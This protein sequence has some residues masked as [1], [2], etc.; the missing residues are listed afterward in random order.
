VGL[1]EDLKPGPVALDTQVFIY[2]IEEDKQFLPLVKPLFEA[3]DQDTL[4]GATSGLTLMEVLVVPYRTGNFSLADRYEALLTRSRGLRFI[5]VDRP[6]L[7]S[8]AQLRAVFRLKPPDA[9]Q[10]AA[11]MVANCQG[12]LTNDRRIPPI[13]GLSVFQLKNYLQ[14]TRAKRN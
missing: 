5:D 8:A 11:A 7:K 6:L 4:L 10:L 2:F 3:I 14:P 12:F 13:P 1:I 9:I